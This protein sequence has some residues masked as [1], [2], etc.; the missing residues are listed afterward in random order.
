MTTSPWT[1]ANLLTLLR[2][3]L[4]PWI[5]WAI[6]TRDPRALWLLAVSIAT[7]LLD[8]LAA[9]TVSRPSTLGALLDPLADKFTLAVSFVTGTAIGLFPLWFA[10]LVVFR[11]IA[12]LATA[13]AILARKK[14]LNVNRF[15]PTP[16]GKY[17]ATA[18]F[19]TVLGVLIAQHQAT[20]SMVHRWLPAWIVACSLL[21]V[22]AGLQYLAR[23]MGDK[24]GPVA[25]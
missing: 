1:V 21:T 18:Q 9:R 8:G 19:F 25:R 23:L 5:G 13:G 3:V 4:A 22:T 14:T 10:C 16:I 20:H 15:E 6:L 11:D 24:L 17:A 2:F 12:Q 7:D